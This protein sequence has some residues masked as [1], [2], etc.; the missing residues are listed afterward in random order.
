MALVSSGTGHASASPRS[1]MATPRHVCF[2]RMLEWLQLP[3]SSMQFGAWAYSAVCDM[4]C[5]APGARP[6]IFHVRSTYKQH[7]GDRFLHMPVFTLQVPSHAN[8]NASPGK[9][10]CA[11]HASHGQLEGCLASNCGGLR[12]R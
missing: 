1:V 11:H 7:V 3:C 8:C 6:W 9:R 5:V 2:R 10:A 4:D 12:G